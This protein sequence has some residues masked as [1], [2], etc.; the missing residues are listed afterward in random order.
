MTIV[1]EVTN[2]DIYEEDYD[3]ALQELEV[4]YK[5]VLVSSQSCRQLWALWVECIRGEGEGTAMCHAP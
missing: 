4:E 2:F 5:D 3:I 1:E